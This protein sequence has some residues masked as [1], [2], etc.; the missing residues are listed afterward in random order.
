MAV[1]PLHNQF[2]PIGD[3]VFIEN[4]EVFFDLNGDGNIDDG[5][6]LGPVTVVTGAGT[7]SAFIEDI[8]SGPLTVNLGTGAHDRLTVEDNLIHGP[9]TFVG[10]AGTFNDVG[11][12]ENRFDGPV[13]IAVGKN[14]FVAFF[15]NSFDTLVADGGGGGSTF[16]SDLQ[17][18][19]SGPIE[20]NG[21]YH[22]N[23]HLVVIK[24]FANVEFDV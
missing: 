1:K 12:F 10:A 5:E 16:D 2:Q 15:D 11:I 23:G 6:P 7:D 21:T 24:R 8:T 20:A 22:V 14:S 18:D 13:T 19:N 3:G 17:D 9:A 4:A